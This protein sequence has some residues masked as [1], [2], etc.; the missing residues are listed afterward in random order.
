[1]P[2]RRASLERVIVSVIA[3]KLFAIGFIFHI[4]LFFRSYAKCEIFHHPDFAATDIDLV[5]FI[6]AFVRKNHILRRDILFGKLVSRKNATDLDG[7]GFFDIHVLR[8][9]TLGFKPYGVIG[10][11]TDRKIGKAF[12]G[13]HHFIKFKLV[14]AERRMSNKIIHALDFIR[15]GE[16]FFNQFIPVCFIRELRSFRA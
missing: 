3:S 1:M 13:I 12:S 4:A 5:L 14:K 8:G 7:I 15:T 10:R 16:F 9:S 6:V 11:A 2:S